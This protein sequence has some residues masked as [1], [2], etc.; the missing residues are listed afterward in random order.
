MR[1]SSLGRGKGQLFTE[2]VERGTSLE[3][4]AGG[5]RSTSPWRSWKHEVLGGEPIMGEG[6]QKTRVTRR[7]RGLLGRQVSRGRNI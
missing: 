2:K 4:N 3:L 6:S 5:G 7:N 1:G